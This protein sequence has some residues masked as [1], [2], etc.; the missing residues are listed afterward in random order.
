MSTPIYRS[1][2]LNHD[3]KSFIVL[4]DRISRG[5]VY[6]DESLKITGTCVDKNMQLVLSSRPRLV[7]RAARG[8]EGLW[9]SPSSL[10]T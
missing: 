7:I 4:Y 6:T 2:F 1:L 8:G 3:T 9:F 10:D 5:Y